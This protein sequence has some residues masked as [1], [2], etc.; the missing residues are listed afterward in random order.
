MRH[1]WLTAIWGFM[2]GPARMSLKTNPEG[3]TMQRVVSCSCYA[4]IIATSI[5]DTTLFEPKCT[6]RNEVHLCGVPQVAALFL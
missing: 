6:P 1:S 4:E 2:L 3:A 5:M